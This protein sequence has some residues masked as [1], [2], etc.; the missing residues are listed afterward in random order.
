MRSKLL[1]CLVVAAFA[2]GVP[3]R[4]L[5]AVYDDFNAPSQLIDRNKWSGFE[6]EGRGTEASRRIDANKLRLFA[7]GA[8]LLVLSSPTGVMFSNFGLSFPNANPVTRLQ[9]TVKVLN[10]A[11]GACTATGATPSEARV[12]IAGNFFNSG[13]R[14]PGS[15]AN[16][17]YADIQLV[18]RANAPENTVAVEARVFRCNNAS[19][20]DRTHLGATPILTLGPPLVCPGRVCPAVTVGINWE[21]ALNRFR[22]VRGGA[23]ERIVTYTLADDDRPGFASKTLSVA[24]LPA[25]CTGTVRRT[26]VMDATFD[27]V[28][29]NAGATVSAL[30]GFDAL[31]L[32]E[33]PGPGEAPIP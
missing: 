1:Y 25:T 19:C 30:G 26:A 3:Q 7:R 32:G 16:D 12:I 4:A 29:V 23:P 6:T 10:F 11:A 9:A 2:V 24:P 15:R 21:Q 14:I 27:N 20:L 8:G 28:V 13:P 17:V 5:G 18:R 31:D 22:F 33:F